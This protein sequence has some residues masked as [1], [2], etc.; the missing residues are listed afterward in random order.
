MFMYRPRKHNFVCLSLTRPAIEL[1]SRTKA[2]FPTNLLPLVCFLALTAVSAFAQPANDF[3]TNAIPLPGPSGVLQGDNTGA[4]PNEPGE[5][6]VP[7]TLPSGIGSSI[8]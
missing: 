7:N 2:M 1:L 8:W 4:Q 6:F 5:P 3:F